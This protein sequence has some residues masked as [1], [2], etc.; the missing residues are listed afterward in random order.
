MDKLLPNMHTLFLHA[1]KTKKNLIKIHICFPSPLQVVVPGVYIIQIIGIFASPP[2]F[3]SRVLELLVKP[4][5]KY[6]E[7]FLFSPLP[8]ISCTLFS[9]FFLINHFF[10]QPTNNS[11]FWKMKNIH[12]WCTANIS[13]FSQVPLNFLFFL[14]FSLCQSS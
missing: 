10:P 14:Y 8:S 13:H 5:P 7:N 1:R 3:L 12:P 9:R 6:S 4:K 11:H 2:P